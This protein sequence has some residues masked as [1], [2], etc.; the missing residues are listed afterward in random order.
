MNTVIPELQDDAAPRRGS[1]LGRLRGLLPQRGA[2]GAARKRRLSRKARI[3]LLLAAAVLVA[4]CVG[5]YQLFFAQEERVAVTGNTT[6]GSLNEALEGSGTTTPAD[7]VTYEVSG[8]VLEWYVEAGD[9]VEEGD[10]LYVLDASEA[11]DEILE[12]E[13][14]LEELYEELAD[15]QENISNQQVTADFSGRIED[16]Q[17]E[18]G[19]SVQSGTVLATLVDDSYMRATLYFS[20]AYQD[21]IYEGMELTVSIPDQMLT[22]TGTVT[23]IQYVDY[24]TTEGM[25]CFAVTVQVENPGSLTQG[26]SATCWLVGDDGSYIYAVDDAQLEYNR[27]QTITA[28][29]SGELTT[30]NVADYER[31]NAGAAL[32]Y[33]DASGY[34]SQLETVQ[35]QKEH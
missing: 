9:Q 24:V 20:Y 1:P 29:A 33:I 25:R 35:K 4:A 14:E 2:G 11:E 26:T 22:P 34:E 21:D 5:L 17:V 32:F 19:D 6:Y 15:L 7:S 28:G 16:L 30:V 18:E 31:V 3:L 13:V 10:L 12:Y 27:E 8:T 23:D